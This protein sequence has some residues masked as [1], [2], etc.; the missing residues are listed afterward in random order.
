MVDN[1][2]ILLEERKQI[3]QYISETNHRF[4][5]LFGVI[6]VPLAAFSGY[7]LLAY[8]KDLRLVLLGVPFLVAAAVALAGSLLIELFVAGHY[9][10]YL[11]GLVNEMLEDGPLLLD[12]L[13][14][15][16]CVRGCNLQTAFF[17]LAGVLFLSIDISCLLIA[18]S[19]LTEVAENR[20]L[21]DGC[22]TAIRIAYWAAIGLFHLVVIISYLFQ[23][24]VKARHLRAT[25]VSRDWR[26]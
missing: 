16:F 10:R 20:S 11:T 5:Q 3:E 4:F 23:Y 1:L 8:E 25:I 13:R 21:S 14:Y 26:P 17:V 2:N 15:D 12:K 9:T 18:P 19:L 6:V 24:T 7:A 22:V